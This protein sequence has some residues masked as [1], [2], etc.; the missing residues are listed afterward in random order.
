MCE[1]Q[2]RKGKEEEEEDEAA[3]E[4]GGKGERRGE[5]RGGEKREK[6]TYTEKNRYRDS[7]RKG[8]EEWGRGIITPKRRN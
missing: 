6:E 1:R 7:E 5:R 2:R 3:A 8:V 4:T